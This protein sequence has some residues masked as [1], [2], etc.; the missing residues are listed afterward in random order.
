MA[1]A[2]LLGSVGVEDLA[3]LVFLGLMLV[4]VYSGFFIL[5]GSLWRVGGKPGWR[6][7]LA[8]VGVMAVTGAGT[9]V[10]TAVVVVNAVGILLPV[11]T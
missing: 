11:F 3:M 1:A 8:F 9:L 2:A 10:A 4:M 7:S 5:C 6:W